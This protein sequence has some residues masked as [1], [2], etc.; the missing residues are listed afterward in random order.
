[1][2]KN[3]VEYRKIFEFENLTNFWW[4][5]FGE[6][7]PEVKRGRLFIYNQI[8]PSIYQLCTQYQKGSTAPVICTLPWNLYFLVFPLIKWLFHK[9]KNS[10]RKS[11][12][13]ASIFHYN[14]EHFWDFFAANYS[15][16]VKSLFCLKKEYQLSL[17]SCNSKNTEYFRTKAH[18]DSFLFNQI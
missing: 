5:R 10:A 2:K 14:T 1:M 12:I 7:W 11:A 18:W 8:L 9:S 3:S 17:E 4:Y 13:F 6:T 16:T 15:G